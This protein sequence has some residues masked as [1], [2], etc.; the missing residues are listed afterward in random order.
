M[1][2][3]ICTPLASPRRPMKLN[4]TASPSTPISARIERP[5]RNSRDVD[6]VVD[7]ALGNRAS[8]ADCSAGS[9]SRSARGRRLAGRA[10]VVATGCC[11]CCRT[12]IRSSPCGRSVQP[13]ASR[14]SHGSGESGR[15]WRRLRKAARAGTSTPKRSGLRKSCRGQMWNSTPSCSSS[16][17]IG[18]TRLSITIGLNRCRSMWRTRLNRMRLG[19]PSRRACRRS[20]RCS[21]F[22]PDL[23]RRQDRV[24][25]HRASQ[26]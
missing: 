5:A 11:E 7:R 2:T 25:V 3:N 6:D 16:W 8:L 10:T 4:T 12:G 21:C 20:S 1:S 13:A 18:P 19:T 23:D 24:G 15:H 22:A 14:C 17:Q 9:R 26:A